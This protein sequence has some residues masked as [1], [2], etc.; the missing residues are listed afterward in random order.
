MTIFKVNGMIL[1][2]PRCCPSIFTQDSFLHLNFVENVWPKSCWALTPYARSNKTL[3]FSF[4]FYLTVTVLLLVR[5]HF[6]E[7]QLSLPGLIHCAKL[8]IIK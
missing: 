2:L 5:R 6:L 7:Q 1:V 4:C 3:L 8:P